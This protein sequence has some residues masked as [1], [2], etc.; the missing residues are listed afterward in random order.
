MSLFWRKV[1]LDLARTLISAGV[2]VG[3]QLAADPSPSWDEVR[4]VVTGALIAAGSAFL[5]ALQAQFTT[6]ESPE[7]TLPSAGPPSSTA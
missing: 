6:L 5:R 3:T 2:V 4:I 1:L 7:G